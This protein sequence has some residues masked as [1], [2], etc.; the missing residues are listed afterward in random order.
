V[1]EDSHSGA[2]KDTL[3][4]EK[5]KAYRARITAAEAGLGVGA[6]RSTE[7]VR[8][9]GADPVEEYRAHLAR[10]ARNGDAF[11]DEA[12]FG[13]RTP[14]QIDRDRILYSSFFMPLA[15]KTQMVIGQH[16]SLLRNRLSHTLVVANIARSIAQGLDLNVDLTEAIAL[17]HDIGHAPFG[18]AG[19]RTLNRW[20]KGRVI[21]L[22]PQEAFAFNEVPAAIREHFLLQ[23]GEGV[24]DPNWRMNL[25]QHGRQS[26]RKLEIFE[27]NNLTRQTLFGIWRHSAKHDKTDGQ[28]AYTFPKTNCTNKNANHKKDRSVNRELDHRCA[29]HE[30]QV[31]R[32]ADDI[33]WAVHDLDDALRAGLVS[34]E[35]I[36]GWK[37]PLEGGDK[38]LTKHLDDYE[39]GPWVRR[40]ISG[41]VD[42]K[43]NLDKATLAAG[44]GGL[45]LKEPLAAALKSLMD[46]VKTLT[47]GD[48]ET[49][50]AEEAVDLLLTNL[51]EAYWRSAPDL[52]DDLEQVLAGRG[53]TKSGLATLRDWL[54]GKKW[55]EKTSPPGVAASKTPKSPRGRENP[56]TERAA[57]ICAFLSA[58]TDEEA[59][60]LWER[61]YSPR[62]RLPPVL[63]RMKS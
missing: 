22:W 55:V 8:L 2:E 20:L 59:M 50:R 41:V 30:A 21:S 33:A 45:T 9:D 23:V 53:Q 32:I 61:R 57:L 1:R 40:F 28:F 5:V 17:G 35:T 58:L 24:Q 18:H 49:D 34:L 44:K 60:M 14:F 26:V 3:I 4:E 10:A 25:F 52:R 16:T 13:A 19:E 6:A 31:V 39:L 7:A 27:N 56:L 62:F 51:A 48:P 43:P 63:A 47:R 46:H 54:G 29:S 15:L 11:G 42:A 12:K 36:R 38:L 37:V